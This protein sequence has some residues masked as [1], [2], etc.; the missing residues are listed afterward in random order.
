VSVKHD[1]ALRK[2]IALTYSWGIA[3]K[4]IAGER[5]FTEIHEAPVKTDFFLKLQGVLIAE[6]PE[7]DAFSKK[8]NSDIVKGILSITSDRFRAPYARHMQDHPRQCFFVGTTNEDTYLTDV[9]GAR[10]FWPIKCGQIRHDFII[11]ARE[12]LFAEA[13]ARYRTGETWWEV[14]E[15]AVKE[16]ELRRS[17]DEWESILRDH[18][19]TKVLQETTVREAAKDALGITYDKLTPKEQ[20]RIARCFKA[21]GWRKE[22]TRRG[23]VW[24]K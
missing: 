24:R 22:H 3:L 20:Q 23:N 18:F 15:D 5:W 21:I 16:Q 19:D 1:D 9:T 17:A 11:D 12:Q 6:I 8:G 7:M 10:R 2:M 13:A 4:L 14:P